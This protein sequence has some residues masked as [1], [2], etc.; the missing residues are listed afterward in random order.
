MF[1]NQLV[2]CKAIPIRDNNFLI[3]Y[4]YTP[5][6]RAEMGKY[7]SLHGVAVAARFFTRKFGHQVSETTLH[8]MKKAYQQEVS[9]K[10]ANEDGDN[11]DY[12]PHQK[13][14]RPVILGASVDG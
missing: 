5:S 9:R 13:R 14:G 4:R 7:T 10:R 6:E 2:A 3:N 1:I 12:L 11:V 8:S